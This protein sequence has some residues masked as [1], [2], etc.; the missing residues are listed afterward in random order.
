MKQKA[1]FSFLVLFCGLEFAV[2]LSSFLY[3]VLSY[4]L[5][6][7]NYFFYFI[8]WW[9][10]QTD[11][12]ILL[13]GLINLL[14]FLPKIKGK[15]AQSYGFILY[16][17][18]AAIL[19]MLFFTVSI[20]VGVIT[21]VNF[22]PKNGNLGLYWFF[23]IVQ[24]WLCPILFI[25]Y[26]ALFVVKQTVNVKNFYRNTLYKFYLHPMLYTILIA[27]RQAVLLIL[28]VDSQLWA[29]TEG[30]NY[31]VPYFFQDFRHP[32]YYI[33]YLVTL[34]IMLFFLIS[35]IIRIN[36]LIILKKELNNRNLIN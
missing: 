14:A 31:Y 34:A 36:N 32:E 24:H 33:L 4:K 29:F 35:I 6:V 19:T 18:F 16:V 2:L 17:L 1:K 15:L 26:Y 5:N 21:K 27:I 12:V 23:T 7:V 13:F 11:V 9:S 28:P 8:S 3:Y 22:V 25:L 20:I 30:I 10:V